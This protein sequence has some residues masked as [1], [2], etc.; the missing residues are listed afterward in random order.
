MVPTFDSSPIYTLSTRLS[1]SPEPFTPSLTIRLRHTLSRW[2]LAPCRERMATSAHAFLDLVPPILVR[3][4]HPALTAGIQCPSTAIMVSLEPSITKHQPPC[5]YLT[6]GNAIQLL[7]P[8]HKHSRY[9]PHRRH[10]EHSQTWIREFA[11]GQIRSRGS[12]R[13]WT[14]IGLSMFGVLRQ[15]ARP[16]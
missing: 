3:V 2:V 5:I 14:K 4:L 13:F 1:P 9:K 12:P 16:R 6:Y 8:H 11:H 7:P 10:H 15:R